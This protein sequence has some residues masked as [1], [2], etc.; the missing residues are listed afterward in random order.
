MKKIKDIQEE[1]DSPIIFWTSIGVAISASTATT[2]KLEVLGLVLS[3]AAGVAI[4]ATIGY[5]TKKEQ[6]K[7]QQKNTK[8]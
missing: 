2:M 8:E 3:V 7:S 4:G 6:E 1:L 5:L